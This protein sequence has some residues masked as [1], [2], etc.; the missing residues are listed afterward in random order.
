MT[1]LAPSYYRARYYDPSVGRFLG[2]DPIRWFS[3]PANF[4]GY[5]HNAPVNLVDPLGLRA[6][7]AATADCIARAFQ[8][9][10]PGVTASVGPATKEVGGHRDFS[11]Q[12]Q[13]SSAD[14]A[15]AFYSA[16]AT[17]SANGWP[18]PARFGSGPALHLENLG[19][20]SPL[21]GTPANGTAHIDLYNPNHG[22]GGL[23]GHVGVDGIVGHLSQIFRSNIDPSACPWGPSCRR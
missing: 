5:V 19:S 12:L 22:L 3:G 8:A 11:V 18:P 13:F 10:F 14:A 2:E 20:W 6:T 15:N 9:L 16:Y 21:S 23:A 17:S 1:D 4:Y 7:E